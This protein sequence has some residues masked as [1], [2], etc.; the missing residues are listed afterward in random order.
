MSGTIAEIEFVIRDV[1]D[2]IGLRPLAHNRFL[3]DLHFPR[4]CGSSKSHSHSG[5]PRAEETGGGVPGSPIWMR[6]RSIDGLSVIAAIKRISA[7][8]WGQ[9]SGS[10]S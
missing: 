7:P 2:S 9:T 10:T 1:L 5:G 6:M 4:P 3:H 8:Q